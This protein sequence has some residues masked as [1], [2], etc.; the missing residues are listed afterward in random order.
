MTDVFGYHFTA[1]K[2]YPFAHFYPND[3]RFAGSAFTEASTPSPEP[4]LYNYSPKNDE[5]DEFDSDE[6][7]TDYKPAKPMSSPNSLDTVVVGVENMVFIGDVDSGQHL[8]VVIR[9]GSDGLQSHFVDESQIA[10]EHGAAE[11]EE[12]KTDFFPSNL[13]V[14]IHSEHQPGDD[15]LTEIKQFVHAFLKDNNLKANA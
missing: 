9:Q 4:I 11:R 1:Y 7:A 15:Q 6:D 14:R 3:D 5:S 10:R 8:R 2:N 13:E 12:E